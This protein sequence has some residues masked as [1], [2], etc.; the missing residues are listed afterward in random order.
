[1]SVAQPTQ[2]T[3][4]EQ[5]ALV[6]QIGL[7]MLR[8][9]P[10]EWVRMTV[11]YRAVGR[12]AEA[13]GRVVFADDGEEA[14]TM[15]PDLQ[16]LFARL[17]GG[18]YR[19]GRGTWFN[20]R[21][22]LDHPS[23][24]NLEY[25]REE[26]AWDNP[27]PPQ[28]YPDDM[29]L[30]PRTDDNVPDWLRG[31]L[32][33]APAPRFRVARI[34]DGPGPSVNRP[35]ASDIAE[36][37][38]YL[39]NAPLAG[40][41]RGYDVD[42]MD[43]EG[44]PPSVPVAFHTDGTWIWPAAVNYYLREHD[45]PPEPDLVEHI[46]RGRFQ[47]PVVDGETRAAAAAFMGV[48]V[49]G[50]PPPGGPPPGGPPP[51]GPGPHGPG[52]PGGAAPTRAMAM[53][54]PGG[55]GAH[56]GP[57]GPGA[58]GPGAP[59]GPGFGGPGAPPPAAL[60]SHGPP[61]RT[62]DALRSRLDELGIPGGAYRIGPP[63]G[64]AWTMDQTEDGWRV[65]WFDREFVAPAMFEDVADASAFL[66]GKLLLDADRWQS[67]PPASSIGAP[68]PPAP[69]PPPHPEPGDFALAA[70]GFTS[71]ARSS[72]HARP[73]PAET[74][75]TPA[76][77]EDEPAETPLPTYD[78]TPPPHE[79]RSFEPFDSAGEYEPAGFDPARAARA[80]ANGFDPAHGDGFDPAHANRAEPGF[81]PPRGDTA[82]EPPR[83][84]GRHGTDDGPLGGERPDSPFGAPD[85][86]RPDSPFGAD[87][88]RPDSPFSAPGRRQDA[89]GVGG[90][91]ADVPGDG[92]FGVPGGSRPDAD[93]GGPR[94]DAPFGAGNGRS[95]RPFGGPEPDAPFGAPNGS[96][97]DAPFGAPDRARP[98]SP[99]D[100]AGG[101]RP[102]VPRADPPFGGPRQEAP[103][104]LSDGQRAEPSFGGARPDS[105]F[106]APGRARPDS[107]LRPGE[108]DRAGSPFE[109]R[110]SDR[111]GARSRPD[112]PFEP[113]AS[114]AGFDARPD[115]PFEPGRGG[116]AFDPAR[117]GSPSFGDS[118][119]GDGARGSRAEPVRGEP[120]RAESF[121]GESAEPTVLAT[122]PARPAAAGPGTPEWPISPLPGEP[123][124][125]LFRGKRLVELE[126]GAEFDRFGDDDGNLV[127]ALGTP[128][129]ERSL[130]PEWID[131]PYHA[132]RVR[133]PVQVLTGSA[134]PWFEQPGGGTAYLL[135]DAVAEL[136]ASGR[137]VELN[138]RERPP[139]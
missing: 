117:V 118:P 128:F 5:D 137:I 17:R 73:D 105:P 58:G 7:A 41:A 136:V 22:R 119:R 123:P 110:R 72:S 48:P 31:R 92:P 42:R 34:F 124:L 134:I 106:G 43:P 6:K 90:P 116:P 33:A 87:G 130:V 35:P 66:L 55:P 57:G 16:A 63:A 82:F 98:D 71:P 24:Y 68:A 49:P 36:L 47:L 79:R 29:R 13:T 81:E 125:T 59:P 129:H 53:P 99:F 40:P 70:D 74:R 56:A 20:A 46:A 109:T 19:D 14:W 9:A 139:A 1:M 51:G 69:V 93:I 91:R 103:F 38:S 111:G 89:S 127:Y 45:V 3:P 120:A 27:P 4:T 60:P 2:L 37:L 54:G 21:Y 138:G 30:F 132:Y 23:S 84:A 83:R 94:Q 78:L 64:R 12:Y 102:D 75:F 65:G 25:D 28:A 61:G 95:D 131:R 114:E 104:G 39:D 133:Q 52:G 62:V 44:R 88:A 101:A 135:P 11:D 85:G 100:P 50:G 80:G 97:S 18:M 67:G 76:P 108:P 15:P 26:P 107:P 77:G 113:A 8:V 112:S 32:A 126:P 86:A 115:A 10:D 121:R 96:R 122:P